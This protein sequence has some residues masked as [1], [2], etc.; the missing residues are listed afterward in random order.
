VQS[1]LDH[2]SRK[3]VQR[4][5]AGSYVVLSDAMSTHDV[6]RGR[7]GTSAALAVSAV[8][9]VVAGI[10]SDRLYPLW[11]QEEIAALLPGCSGL[12]VVESVHGHDGFLIEA[13]AVGRLVGKALAAAPPC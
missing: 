6:G 8:P 7:G 1:Y 10:D 5:D 2:H 3:L 13:D 4:F 9:T 12:E 11:Q